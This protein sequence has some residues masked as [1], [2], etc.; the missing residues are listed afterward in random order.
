M[1]NYR[2]ISTASRSSNFW[3]DSSLFQQYLVIFVER[4]YTV[5]LPLKGAVECILQRFT[6]STLLKG[7]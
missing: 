3:H 5:R 1:M 2:P 4:I 7:S 6:S